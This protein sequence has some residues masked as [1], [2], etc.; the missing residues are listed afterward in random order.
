MS[1]EQTVGQQQ[2][3]PRPQPA[4]IDEPAETATQT[5][6]RGPRFGHA[7]AR[8]TSNVEM[9]VIEAELA[10]EG[11]EVANPAKPVTDRTADDFH[12]RLESHEDD[13]EPAWTRPWEQEVSDDV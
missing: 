7:G 11:T 2:P 5:D 6:D 12:E 13:L 9:L 3:A 1:S 8:R 4:A 10:A